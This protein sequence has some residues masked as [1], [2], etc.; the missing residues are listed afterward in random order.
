MHVIKEDGFSSKKDRKKPCRLIGAQRLTSL[1]I[2][3]GQFHSPTRVF[4]HEVVI[5]G[6]L[7]Y[8]FELDVDAANFTF[9]ESAFFSSLGISSANVIRFKPSEIGI[10]EQLAYVTNVQTFTLISK[11]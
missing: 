11:R 4:A 10:A 7:H 8:L 3:L 5:D 1:D 6:I 2:L 9:A